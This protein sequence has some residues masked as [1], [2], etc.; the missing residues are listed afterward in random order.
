MVNRSRD[1]RRRRVVLDEVAGNTQ[2]ADHL[3]VELKPTPEKNSPYAQG[4]LR[5]HHAKTSDLFPKRL[6]AFVWTV[7]AMTGAIG[8]INGIDRLSAY[9]S[10][11]VGPE[12][13]TA[14]KVGHVGSI[15]SWY[16]TFLLIIAALTSIQIYSLRQHR[17]DDY[18]G[19]YRMWVWMAGLF[20][21]ASAMSVV[22]GWTLVASVLSGVTGWPDS[23]VFWTFFAVQAVLLLAI[24]L[25]VFF[26]VRAS[27]AATVMLVVT[28][29][30]Y[31]GVLGM[32][33]SAVRELLPYPPT[34][35]AGNLVVGAH[36]LAWLTLAVYLRFV[37][38]EAHGL[39]APRAESG[40]RA[41]AADVAPAAQ[42]TGLKQRWGQWR[43]SRAETRA[44]K[45]EEKESAREARRAARAERKAAAAAE[46]AKAAEAEKS[47]DVR[48]SSLPAAADASTTGK[49]SAGGP[50][51]N[52]IKSRAVAPSESKTAND[53]K[54]AN[55]ESDKGGSDV[56]ASAESDS[57][58]LSPEELERLENEI[59]TLSDKPK[60]SKSDRRR[61]KKLQKR[62]E[63]AA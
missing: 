33:L 19:R 36:S 57:A 61:L 35:V 20:L 49:K 43:A 52:R 40:R 25:R 17:N 54:S 58:S 8:C 6:K 4:A 21:V 56:K 42:R 5:R 29:M 26:E 44:R 12:Q 51:A 18:R 27:R 22:D 30:A 37:F 62:Y 48:K 34:L 10:E 16:S 9:L 45:K 23:Q 7:L 38:F 47:D 28:S 14:L 63:R 3:E 31:A 1:Q 13:L 55:R 60:L 39:L 59:L 15:A 41:K 2:T 11:Y 50:L 24:T 53:S 32:T 46:R